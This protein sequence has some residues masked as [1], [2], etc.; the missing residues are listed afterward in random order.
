MPT[1]REAHYVLDDFLGNATDLTLCEHA[2]DTHDVTLIRDDTPTENSPS[3]VTRCRRS[4]PVG[5]LMGGWCVPVAVAGVW[6]CGRRLMSGL[7][8][9][10]SATVP[11]RW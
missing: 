4:L 1:A 8:A 5:A 3:W 10:G 6:R 11:G 9:G 2:T 7:V